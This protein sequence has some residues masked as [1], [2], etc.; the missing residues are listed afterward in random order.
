[1]AIESQ[2]T[3]FYWGDTTALSTASTNMV[4]EVKTF[5][6]PSGSAKVI[7]ITHLG[8]TAAEKL[9]G[10]RD[11]GQI[12]FECNLATTN[13]AQMKIVADR[14]ARTKKAWI[15]KLNDNSSDTAKMR[16]KGDGYCT[17]FAI[18]GGVDDVIKANITLEI[19]GAV[20]WS[21]TAP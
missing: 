18:S 17:G 15:I 19:T 10:L 4:G 16:L 3:E 9:I 14:N 5:N 13:P 8:S 6:G 20:A 12:T 21:T 11:E 1:M 7:P 2:G